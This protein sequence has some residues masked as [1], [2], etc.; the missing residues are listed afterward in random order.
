MI[1]C[2]GTVANNAPDAIVRDAM[3][4]KSRSMGQPRF[5]RC[6]ASPPPLWIID[7]RPLSPRT[8]G[9]ERPLPQQRMGRRERNS[10]CARVAPEPENW[11]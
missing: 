4:R 3:L 8:L 1:V 9:D 2:A 10:G 7:P 6:M 11:N 5:G